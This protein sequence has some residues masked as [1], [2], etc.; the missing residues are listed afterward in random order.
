[1]VEKMEGSQMGILEKA[2]LFFFEVGE[3]YVMKFKIASQ[4]TENKLTSRGKKCQEK[5][6]REDRET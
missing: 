2:K 6:D 4:A 5:E 1:M 3:E